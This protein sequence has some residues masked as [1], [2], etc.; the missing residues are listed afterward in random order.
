[1]TRFS[2]LAPQDIE[3]RGGQGQARCAG[4]PALRHLDF[5]CTR[6]IGIVTEMAPQDGTLVGHLRRDDRL[7]HWK[8]RDQV[9]RSTMLRA[10]KQD[11]SGLR[12]LDPRHQLAGAA[13]PG[14][15][16]P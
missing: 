3:V 4:H 6:C 9:V 13:K 11:V 12:T 7:G 10:P 14:H 1:M 5:L 8:R 15:R 2:F 16:N